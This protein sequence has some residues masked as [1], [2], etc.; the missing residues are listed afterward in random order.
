MSKQLNVENLPHLSKEKD[1][2]E[3]SKIEAEEDVKKMLELASI[4]RGRYHSKERSRDYCNS[5]NKKE[6]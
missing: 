1:F 5:K 2:L 6:Y 3:K 4:L